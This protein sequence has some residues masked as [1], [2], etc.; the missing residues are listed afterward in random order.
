MRA[1]ARL[2]PNLIFSWIFHPP[3]AIAMLLAIATVLPT[4]AADKASIEIVHGEPNPY[5]QSPFAV[6]EAYAEHMTDYRKK[7]DH[8]SPINYSALHWNH[9][10]SIFMNHSD[11]IYKHNYIEFLKLEEMLE[12]DEEYDPEFKLYPEGVIFIKEHFLSENGSPGKPTIL[13]IM[14]KR[15]P[16]YDPKYNDWEYVH[17]SE[18]GQVIISGNSSSPAIMQMCLECHANMADRDYIF[19][20]SHKHDITE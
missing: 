5:D 6:P 19:S 2:L 15:E 16:G 17:A 14:I 20:L 9:F 11:E 4:Y 10:V 1:H 3:V 8:V 12:E 18:T 13:S 7:W